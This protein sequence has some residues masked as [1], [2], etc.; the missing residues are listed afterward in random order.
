MYV[1]DAQMRATQSHEKRPRIGA[2]AQLGERLP[3]TQEVSGSIPLSSTI[4]CEEISDKR[5]C[6]YHWFFMPEF[7]NKVK[8]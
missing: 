7:F 2:I 6:V 4:H 1:T 3:C 5:V 8:C